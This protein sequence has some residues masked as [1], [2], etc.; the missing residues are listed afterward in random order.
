M[1][2]TRTNVSKMVQMA[3][4]AAIIILMAFTPLGYLR[5]PALE[6][7][8]L[9][10]PVA[11]AAIL[12]GPAGGAIA[13]G[14][15]GVTSFIQCFG[16][17]WFGTMLFSINPFFTFIICIIPRILAGWLPGLLYRAL[18]KIG[19]N[20]TVSAI[21]ACL[22][23][24]LLN[25]VLFVAT[26]FLLFGSTDFVRGF[27]ESTWAIIVVLVGLNGLI[28]AGVGFIAGSTVSRT[29]VHFFPGNPQE[30]K[31]NKEGAL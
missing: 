30:P 12:V 11:I 1:A 21:Y 29:L 13:G 28:E 5:T 26:L 22:A 10:I 31:P 25:T 3:I 9:M 17:S 19:K 27:G 20:K 23:A 16:L 24:P 2:N 15:F 4:L 18:I 14:I 7:T 8:F 6:I